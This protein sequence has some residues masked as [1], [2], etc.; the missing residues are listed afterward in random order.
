MTLHLHSC[1]PVGLLACASEMRELARRLERWPQTNTFRDSPLGQRRTV[2]QI[3]V[4]EAAI[5]ADALRR[6]CG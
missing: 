3:E 4:H 2:V 5:C 1:H 6:Q